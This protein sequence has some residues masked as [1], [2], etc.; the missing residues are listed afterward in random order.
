MSIKG[1]N[2]GQL[3]SDIM[4]YGP[5]KSQAS[6]SK[7]IGISAPLFNMILKGVRKRPTWDIGAKIITAHINVME[8]IHAEVHQ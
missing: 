6:A 4:E 1:P 5:Y 2:F 7:A 3:L 8:A